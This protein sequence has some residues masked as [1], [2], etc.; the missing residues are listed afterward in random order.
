M[1]I[2]YN[3]FLIGG[4]YYQPSQRYVTFFKLATIYIEILR[5]MK[6]II[7]IN[8][9]QLRQIVNESVKKVLRENKYN[10]I[11]NFCSQ[12]IN[13]DYD[14]EICEFGDSGMGW[15]SDLE[16]SYGYDKYA[17][18]K[19]YNAISTRFSI[20]EKEYE[21]RHP[22]DSSVDFTQDYRKKAKQYVQ[23]VDVDEDNPFT[24][25]KQKLDKQWKRQKEAAK[26]GKQAD[27]RLLHHK[28]SAN[29]ELMDMGI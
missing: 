28:G 22:K 10:H 23:D 4:Y 5:E 7:R 29:R 12:I 18:T 14:S 2:I 1:T 17:W 8:E 27:S 24:L 19:I 6:Q 21:I 11:D 9:N 3:Y 26:Y 13:G 16:A 25:L 15:F 20:L